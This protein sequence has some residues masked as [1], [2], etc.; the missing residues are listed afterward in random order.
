MQISVLLISTL[1]FPSEGYHG[2]SQTSNIVKGTGIKYEV[3]LKRD[4]KYRI[5]QRNLYKI[6]NIGIK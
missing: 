3:K 4:R 5:Q 1:L 2:A 6:F